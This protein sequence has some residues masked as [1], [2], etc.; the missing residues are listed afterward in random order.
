SGV[1][2]YT[3]HI[4]EE[5]KGLFI[6]L[7]RGS[8]EIKKYNGGLFSEELSDSVKFNDIRNKSFFKE[9]KKYKF[10][11]ISLYE[12]EK[13]LF[14]RYSGKLNPLIENLLLMA[15][16]DF[17]T[18]VNVN[19]LGHI[20]E[21]SIGDLEDLAEGKISKRKKE[22]IFYT[23]EYI[24]DYI[25][26]NTII[27][28]LSKSNLN[29]VGKLVGEYSDD[30]SELEDK[31][32]EIKILDPACGSGAFLIKGVD[33]LLEIHEEIDKYKEE[34]GHYETSEK[35]KRGKKTKTVNLDK[36]VAEEKAK[37]I[38]MN[39]IFGV[40]INEE[41][42]E[43]T[44]LSLFLK[45]ARKGKKLPVLDNNIRCGNSLIDDKSVDSKA[46]NWHSREKG[47]GG[48]MERRGFDVVIGNPPYVRNTSLTPTEKYFFSNT[49][50]TAKGQFDLYVLFNE[51]ALKV[52]KSN[53]FISFIQPNKF[54]SADYGVNT[55]NLINHNSKISRI[56]NVSLDKVFEDA[57]VYPYI[58]VYKKIRFDKDIK[59]KK[60]SIYDICSKP[61][62]IGFNNEIKAKD[63]VKKIE[64]NSVCLKDISSEIKRGVPNTKIEFDEGG[65]FNAI[66]SSSLERAYSLPLSREKI[67]YKGGEY[68]FEKI[69]IL[70]PRTTLRIKAI[71]KNEE[72][73]ILDR[74]YYFKINK[75]DFETKFVLSVINSKLTSYLYNYHF[76][77]TKVGGGYFDLKG[78]QINNFLIPDIV[79]KEQKPFIEKAD[80]MLKLNK[81]FYEK[82]LKFTNRINQNLNLQ[83]ITKKLNNFFDLDF[84][85]FCEEL[86]KQKVEFS[87]KEQD[88]WEDYFNQYKK[89]LSSLK[90]YIEATDKEIDEMVYKLYGL[91]NEEIKIVEESLK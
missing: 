59:L 7:D 86:K 37:D 82:K 90:E 65:K 50:F 8:K 21:Q 23:P 81:E 24:T 63:L 64:C 57:S 76:G 74:I 19:I 71:Y 34:Q 38:I 78:T 56:W 46:F 30:L 49:Y 4:S 58:F 44:K 3:H 2:E 54:L 6:E 39:N 29:E 48:I 83:K 28:Y 27:P 43:I 11:K 77:S 60:L 73:H 41:S 32:Q 1:K 33:V 18:E 68:K 36:Y 20:F 89:E 88:E 15:S 55:L 87:L 42:V 26:R 72:S 69:L 70:L 80:L 16:F 45:I 9:N 10:G 14:N 47:F 61:C 22:G 17:N 13:E 25:C 85:Q 67:N 91:T 35:G 31:L 12:E 51:L 5:I 84:K 53:G 79:L 66:K 40:D 62:L 75:N 52:A